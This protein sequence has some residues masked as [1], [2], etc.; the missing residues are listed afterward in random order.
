MAESSVA[1]PGEEIG[2]P[3]EL[4]PEQARAH[5]AAAEQASVVTPADLRVHAA[6]LASLGVLVATTLAGIWWALSSGA[7]ALFV[8]VMLAYGAMLFALILVVRRARVIPRGFQRAN[9]WGMGLTMGLYAVGV[10]WFTSR[11]DDPLSAGV[12]LPYCV[13]VA[14][15][16]LLA[17][18]VIRRGGPGR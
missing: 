13:L 5:L 2:P 3:G 10:A 8:V 7:T 9:G 1:G 11:Q 16:S 4:T 18:R 6:Y 12:F 15:P 17:A 14:I